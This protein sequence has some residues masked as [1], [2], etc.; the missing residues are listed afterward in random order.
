MSKYAVQDW[1][2]CR[3]RPAGENVEKLAEF[4]EVD[5]ASFKDYKGDRNQVE[6]TGLEPAT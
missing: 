4:L 1:E 2:N 3:Y 6:L 5:V